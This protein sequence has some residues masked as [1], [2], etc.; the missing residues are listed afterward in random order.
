M[1][2]AEQV[3]NQRSTTTSPVPIDAGHRI[4]SGV[5]ETEYTDCG[6]LAVPNCWVGWCDQ[7]TR[8]PSNEDQASEPCGSAAAMT[9]PVL[10]ATAPARYLLCP[11]IRHR[12]AQETVG[13]FNDFLLLPDVLTLGIAPVGR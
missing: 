7:P 9:L 1:P 12:H 4:A 13:R 5:T 6:S 10:N 2:M 8:D 11:A 3:L